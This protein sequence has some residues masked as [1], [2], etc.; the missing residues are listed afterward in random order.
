MNHINIQNESTNITEYIDSNILEKIYNLFSGEVTPTELDHIILDN[1][2]ILKGNITVPSV[3]KFIYDWL[4]ERYPNTLRINYNDLYI[5]IKDPYIE[6]KLLENNFGDSTNS[7]V[8]YSKAF[9]ATTL[10]VFGIT[11]SY[12]EYEENI[13]E[14]K[15]LAEFTNVKK[16]S[17]SIFRNCK[18][19][20]TVDLVNITELEDTVFYRSGIKHCLNS[21]N[22]EIIG[23]QCF[24][25]CTN[26]ETFDF[27]SIKKIGTHSIFNTGLTTIHFNGSE[28]IIL[29]NQAIN[30]NKSL[31]VIDGLQNVK[32]FTA[33]SIFSNNTALLELRLDNL[34]LCDGNNFVNNCTSLHTFYAPKL[35]TKIEYGTF[36]SC[37]AL[38]NLTID[39]EN[40]TTI[41]GSAFNSCTSL[42]SDKV[43]ISHVTEFTGDRHFNECS[44]LTSLTLNQNIINIP[45]YFCYKCTNLST[46]NLTNCTTIGAYVFFNTSLVNVDISA[47]S[48]LGGSVFSGVNTLVSVNLCSDLKTLNGSVFKNCSNL[49]NINTNSAVITSIGESTF[50]GCKSLTTFDVSSVMSLGA[51]S[52]AYCDNLTTLN[53]SSVITN[54]PNQCFRTNPKL[55]SVGDLSG[56]KTIEKYAFLD[57]P[58]L[59]GP[60]DLSNCETINE[61]AFKG[62]SALTEVTLTTKCTLIKGEAFNG[63]TNLELVGDLS[64]VTMLGTHFAN[65]MNTFRGCSSLVSVNLSNKCTLLCGN[66]FRGC[67]SLTSVGDIS[68]L[69]DIYAGTF[70]DCS[71]LIQNIDLSNITGSIGEAA[72]QGCSSL[73]SILV[74]ANVQKIDQNAFKD[75]PLLT[76]KFLGITPP[77][78]FA[79]NAFNSHIYKILVPNDSLNSYK[80]KIPESLHSKIETY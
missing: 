2:S 63:C 30:N 9:A 32:Q 37:K 71:S 52:F 34:E 58:L 43:D 61:S 20:E 65:D 78:N 55:T 10:P 21:G 19:I 4:L 50:E 3:Y 12:N 35:A 59:T 41:K 45:E 46:I 47:C 74:G 64:N 42:T 36:G 29:M 15:E 16:L 33:N 39:W 76:V 18:N 17:R 44:S 23:A 26:L 66:T 40:I 80:V 53:I 13:A 67:T 24:E 6:A 75:C 73:T 60:L 27:S 62:C 28:D 48:S 14:F 68:G 11:G 7:H 70:H 54:I 38:K 22:V 77:S 31:T 5:Y 49:S 56:V 51:W 25:D 69:T 8:T 79:I 57:C 72:F 1:T